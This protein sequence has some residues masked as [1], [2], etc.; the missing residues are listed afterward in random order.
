MK[1]FLRDN[2]EKVITKSGSPEFGDDRVLNLY[3]AKTMDDLPESLVEQ[4]ATLDR[5]AFSVKRTFYY[6]SNP[7]WGVWDAQVMIN[8]SR[9]EVNVYICAILV[10]PFTDDARAKYES[11]MGFG[12]RKRITL[13]WD[14]R[15]W[16][17]EQLHVGA[18]VEAVP[19][20]TTPKKKRVRPTL[21]QVRALEARIVEVER[22][23]AS[24]DVDY[25]RLVAERE[26]L[27]KKLVRT[28]E[29]LE[30]AR[31]E[32]NTAET[33]Y[34]NV[35]QEKSEEEER[36]NKQIKEQSFAVKNL[37]GLNDEH[38][39]EIARLRNRGLWAR[40]FNL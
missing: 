26:S 4:W 37:N 29:D 9:K 15:V 25:K 21:T 11:M 24:L 1:D 14:S 31:K 28:E 23:Y 32:R 6:V 2:Y 34:A 36:L 35:L 30:R 12:P 16:E 19:A 27:R 3:K 13:M 17:R 8:V 22:K 39:K 33:D 18:A 20:D 7:D 10:R 38:L 5:F 40:I